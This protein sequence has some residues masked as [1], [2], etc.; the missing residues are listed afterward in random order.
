MEWLLANGDTARN[1][2]ECTLCRH[3]S[4]SER[5]VVLTIED[6][7]AGQQRVRCCDLECLRRLLAL[8]E[9]L[10]IKKVYA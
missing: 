7:Q 6:G 3:R 2:W 5:H 1:T 9:E 8:W 4:R 10:E